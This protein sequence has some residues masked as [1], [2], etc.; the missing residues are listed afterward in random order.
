[1]SRILDLMFGL[2]GNSSTGDVTAA[3]TPTTSDDSKKL[4][5]TQWARV[6]F[7]VSLATNGYIKFPTWLGGLIIQWGK[8]NAVPSG[9]AVTV[10]FPIPF[11]NACLTNGATINNTAGNGTA[12]SAGVGTPNQSNMGVFHNGANTPTAITWYAI[13]Y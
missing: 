4:A 3:N 1:M 8:Q 5:T 2:T 7:A 9:S 12:L 10:T 11:P 13:G 6:G